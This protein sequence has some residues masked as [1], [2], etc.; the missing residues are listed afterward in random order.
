MI[1]L[2]YNYYYKLVN[3]KPVVCNMEEGA[4]EFHK[5]RHVAETNIGDIFI[6]TV[7]LVINHA[8]DD[9]EPILFE[10]MI[11]GG[12]HGGYCERYAT[13]EEA[14]KGHKRAVELCN[15]IIKK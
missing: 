3:K 1:D 12:V 2:N 5:E 9:G 6:S 10:T 15:Q 14:E 4:L 13:W 7:F 11:F 8:F